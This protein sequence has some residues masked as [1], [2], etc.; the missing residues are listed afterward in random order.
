MTEM[1]IRILSGKD[2]T[3][4]LGAAG[5]SSMGWMGVDELLASQWLRSTRNGLALWTM[6]TKWAGGYSL[7][8]GYAWSGGYSWSGGTGIY[9]IDP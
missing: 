1:R 4:D 7:S 9:W 8:G 3:A 5:N 2:I 6:N